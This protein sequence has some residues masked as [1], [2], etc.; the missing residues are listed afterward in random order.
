MSEV[1]GLL[2]TFALFLGVMGLTFQAYGEWARRK[3]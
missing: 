3:R 2:L 1:F